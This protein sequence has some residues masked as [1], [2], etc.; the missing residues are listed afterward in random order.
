MSDDEIKSQK[1]QTD[2]EKYARSTVK[3]NV[4]NIRREGHGFV[5]CQHR[6]GLALI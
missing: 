5:E 6:D 2:K 4:I 1:A 3:E